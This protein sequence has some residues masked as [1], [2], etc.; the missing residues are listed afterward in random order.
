MVW[1]VSWLAIVGNHDHSVQMKMLGYCNC[2]R[3]RLCTIEKVCMRFATFL[4]MQINNKKTKK[5]NSKAIHSTL[6]K[7]TYLS[8]NPVPIG[9]DLIPYLEGIKIPYR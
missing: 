4:K 5:D 6:Q 3:L 2:S 1:T 7:M 8:G 9:R